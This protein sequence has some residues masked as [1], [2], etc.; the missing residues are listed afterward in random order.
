MHSLQLYNIQETKTNFILYPSLIT[1]IKIN[2]GL[3][4]GMNRI[5]NFIVFH[6]FSINSSEHNN[7]ISYTL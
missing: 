5:A 7:N 1:V 4:Y 3:N 6:V 2:Y